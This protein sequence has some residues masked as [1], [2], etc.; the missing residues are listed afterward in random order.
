MYRYQGIPCP[1]PCLP[2]GLTQ[3]DIDEAYGYPVRRGRTEEE[4]WERADRLMNEDED[5]RAAEGE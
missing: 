3:R 4:E 2:A 5:R 1:D